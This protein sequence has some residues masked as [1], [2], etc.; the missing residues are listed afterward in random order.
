VVAF[1]AAAFITGAFLPVLQCEPVPNLVTGVAGFAA[2]LELR[3]LLN[4]KAGERRT[5]F[6]AARL[7]GNVA[8]RSRL[9]SNRV[10]TLR[11]IHRHL[12]RVRGSS[13][14]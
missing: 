7:I 12:L 11:S 3:A 8:C 14:K 2:P 1:R 9:H 4:A 6:E 10:D 13:L 5:L